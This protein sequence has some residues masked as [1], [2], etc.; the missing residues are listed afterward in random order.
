MQK[1]N[2]KHLFQQVKKGIKYLGI[3]A[4]IIA[5]LMSIIATGGSSGSGGGTASGA[6]K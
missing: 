5:G 6:G 2:R 1:N 4:L 3:V